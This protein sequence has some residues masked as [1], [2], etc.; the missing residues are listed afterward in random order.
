[1]ATLK[2]FGATGIPAGKTV[3]VK[4]LWK[5]PAGATKEVPA[6]TATHPIITYKDNQC[7]EQVQ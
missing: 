6:P 2:N 4:F 3:F 7:T 5:L 1:V